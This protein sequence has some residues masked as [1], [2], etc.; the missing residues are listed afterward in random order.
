MV[1]HV[2]TFGVMGVNRE[3]GNV[4]C[5]DII[6]KKVKKRLPKCASCKSAKYCSSICQKTDW[7]HHRDLCRKTRDY[8]EK[9][10]PFTLA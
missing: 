9:N 5:R 8:E 4:N 2:D 3:M 10:A 1:L 6:C 7:N